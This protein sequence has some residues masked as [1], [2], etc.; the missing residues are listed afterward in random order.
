MESGRHGFRATRVM[1]LLLMMMMMIF[2]RMKA[3]SREQSLVFSCLFFEENIT[4]DVH[5]R[6]VLDAREVN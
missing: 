6:C 4:H 5:M 1:L 3:L 2:S